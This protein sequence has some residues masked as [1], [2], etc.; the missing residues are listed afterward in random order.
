MIFPDDSLEQ[1]L[2][3][4]SCEE[5]NS[6]RDGAKACRLLPSNLSNHTDFVSQLSADIPGKRLFVSRCY[7]C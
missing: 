6:S 5:S 4:G 1:R 2:R 3:V 7:L